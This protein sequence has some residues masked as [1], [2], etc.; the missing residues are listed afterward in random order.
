M[1]HG[2]GQNLAPEAVNGG[3]APS[4]R[5]GVRL[6]SVRKNSWNGCILKTCFVR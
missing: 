5:L 4:Y 3:R 1:R 6:P 2:S